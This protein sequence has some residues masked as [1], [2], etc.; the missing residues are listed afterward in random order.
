MTTIKKVYQEV[1]ALLEANKNSLVADLMPQLRALM[2]A[3]VGGSSIGATHLKDE[4]GNV[5]AVY[6]YYHKKWE[7]VANHIYGAKVGTTTGLNS[8]CKLG[9]NQWTTQQRVAK[10]AKEDLLTKLQSGEIAVEDLASEQEAI[11]EQRNAIVYSEAYPMAYDTLEELKESLA[12]VEQKV[13]KPKKA[14]KKKVVQDLANEDTS[15]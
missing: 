14:S 13:T 6:C 1:N 9:V 7:L 12:N 3:K 2:S 4:E 5:I 15:F 10:K 8:M 11:E